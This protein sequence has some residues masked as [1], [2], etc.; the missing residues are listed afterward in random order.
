MVTLACTLQ[1]PRDDLRAS[2]RQD[3]AVSVHVAHDG[4]GADVAGRRSDKQEV[5]VNVVV[6]AEK[7]GA[8][9]RAGA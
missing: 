7:R 4:R 6:I 5:D 9:W 2:V 1:G 8:I 3:P